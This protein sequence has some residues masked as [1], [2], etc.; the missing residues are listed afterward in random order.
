MIMYTANR[1][2]EFRDLPYDAVAKYGILQ[3]IIPPSARRITGYYDWRNMVVYATFEVSDASTIQPWVRDAFALGPPTRSTQFTS[4]TDQIMTERGER[5][6]QF[7]LSNVDYWCAE[8][9]FSGQ[10][11]PRRSVLVI[12]DPKANRVYLSIW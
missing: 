7:S 6:S 3:S 1:P 5:R 9:T 2:Y 11:F 4:N 12:F 8:K 10:R